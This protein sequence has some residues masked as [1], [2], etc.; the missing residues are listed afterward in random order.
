[1]GG[2]AANR[3]QMAI[4]RTLLVRKKTHDHAIQQQVQ[5]EFIAGNAGGFC[6]GKGI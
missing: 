1:M 3:D 2:V 5:S 4:P 6:N